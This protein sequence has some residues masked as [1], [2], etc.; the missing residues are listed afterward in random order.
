MAMAAR[1]ATPTQALDDLI[2]SEWLHFLQLG[3]Y[4][5]AFIDN[6]YDD[7]E[8][9]KRIGPE[10]LDAI[11]VASVHHRAFLLDAVRVLREQGAA[12][13][14]LLLGARSPPNHPHAA[15]EWD[16]HDRVSASSGIASANSWLEEPELSGSSC[17]QDPPLRARRLS[18]QKSHR[19]RAG[20]KSEASRGPSTTPSASAATEITDCP[21]SSDTV[22]VITSISRKTVTVNNCEASPRPPDVIQR[23]PL[24]QPHTIVRAQL[25]HIPPHL[26]HFAA[27]QV[28]PLHLRMLVREKLLDEGIRLSAHPY[29]S[30]QVGQPVFYLLS[31][32]HK[33]LLPN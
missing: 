25:H 3:H 28:N 16:N 30:A 21:S 20:G 27:R 7:L 18:S 15:A 24:A 14:Y 8:T 6:G 19:Q 26:M 17:D 11:G 32:L 5:R 22:S 33:Y 13:V 31:Y 12:W 23:P 2:V 9:V 29:T 4:S 10:D 1:V